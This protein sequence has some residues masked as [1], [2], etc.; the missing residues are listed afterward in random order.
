MKEVIN[1]HS[2]TE[3]IEFNGNNQ[4]STFN[5]KFNFLQEKII[6]ILKNDERACNDYAYLYLRLLESQGVIKIINL[7]KRIPSPE[8]IDRIRRKLKENCFDNPDLY[9]LK[10][11]IKDSDEYLDLESREFYR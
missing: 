11:F 6:N 10:K 4:I 8:S 9:F 2:N 1:L 3:T 7:D 5:N